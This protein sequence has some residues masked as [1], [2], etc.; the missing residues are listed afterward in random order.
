[1]ADRGSERVDGALYWRAYALYKAGRRDEA[2]ASLAKLQKE[3]PSSAWLNDA[4]ALEVEVR[5]ASGQPVSPEKEQDEELKLLALNSLVHSEPERSLP[6][7]EKLLQSAGSP[8]LKERA[9]FVLAQSRAPRAMELLTQFAKGG[10]NPDLQLK[11]VEY[12]GIF[13]GKENRQALAEIYGSSKNVEVKRRVLQGYMMAKDKER[14]LAA[15][16]GESSQELRGDAAHLLGVL[17][18]KDELW[19]LYQ[20]EQAPEVRE[21]ILHGLFIG[22]DT[23]KVLE[24]ARTEKDPKLRRTAIHLLGTTRQ[25]EAGEAL[26]SMYGTEADKDVRREILRGLF[27]NQNVKGLIDVARK[28]NDPDLKRESVRLL[29]SMKSKEA[30]D[31]LMELLK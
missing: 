2:L 19:Q 13:G 4:R 25:P 24:A 27:V 26:V 18:A 14:L 31:Y 21:R 3:H 17:G 12:L 16:R 20:G 8:K 7:L 10:A 5:Q 29:S 11:A 15:A 6:I 1:V 22:K 9:L 30:T 23:D 28:E